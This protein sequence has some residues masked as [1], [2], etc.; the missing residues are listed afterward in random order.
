M[1]LKLQE[2]GT[3]HHNIIPIHICDTSTMTHPSENV[4]ISSINI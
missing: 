4:K 1:K 2:E 3:D